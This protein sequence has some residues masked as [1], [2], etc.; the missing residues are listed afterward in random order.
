MSATGP[1][2]GPAASQG[3]GGAQI[4]AGIPTVSRTRISGQTHTNKNFQHS[5]LHDTPGRKKTFSDCDFSYSVFYRC[6]F[7]EAKFENCNFTGCRFYDCNFIDADFL[8]CDLK[9]ALFERCQ[10]DV[11]SIL[12]ALPREPNLRRALIQNLRVNANATGDFENQRLLVLAQVSA[13]KDYLKH[14]I[15]GN[16]PYYRKKFPTSIDRIVAALRFAA[17]N[18]SGFTWGHGERIGSLA[19]SSG[20]LLLLLSMLNLYALIP[21]YG[22]KGGGVIPQSLIYTFSLFFDVPLESGFSGFLFVDFLILVMRYIYFG[23]LVSMLYKSI[24]H[25]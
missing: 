24:S 23:L 20:S 5:E 10:V 8:S 3:G 1:T 6:Y 16:Q 25:R 4:P 18:V 22:W 13:T 2:T 17:V 14:A 11:P 12:S 21:A 9:Y 15:L 19:I 7:K